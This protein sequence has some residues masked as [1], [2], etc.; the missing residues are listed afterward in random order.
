MRRNSLRVG[1]AF[2]A[3]TLLLSLLPPASIAVSILT[4]EAERD[5]IATAGSAECMRCHWM[6]TMAYRDSETGKIVDLSIGREAY[7]H[8]VHAGLAC[9]DCHAR[10]YKHYPHRASSADE[11]LT[12]V[13]CHAERRDDGAADLAEID[14]EYEHSVHAQQAT[15]RFD[16]FSC[17][18]PHRFHPVAD[19]A[20]VAEVVAAN[21][22]L[23]LDCHTELESPV[24]RGHDWLPR[25]RAH[26][27][28]VR[29]IDCHTPLEGRDL[30]APSHLLLGA[31]ESNRNCVECHSKGSVLLA[32]LYNHR[33]EQEREEKGFLSQALYNDAYIVGMSRSPL[34]DRVGLAVAGMLLIG[35]TAHGFGRYLAQKRRRESQ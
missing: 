1:R 15:N 25:P 8:S 32:Q 26:W 20:P 21:N 29:C 19:A 27:A 9:A 16:C 24:P 34:M 23:C 3:V 2:I 17:H 31:A 6:E 18:N 33:V 13:G 10:A 22:G 28:A 11:A 12:C 7:R 4:D 35:I 14:L 5:G 30:Y